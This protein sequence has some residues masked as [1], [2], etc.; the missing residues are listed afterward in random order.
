VTHIVN[1]QIN[2][3]LKVM[4]FNLFQEQ[5]IHMIQI[6]VITQFSGSMITPCRQSTSD[7]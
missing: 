3:L 4:E 5:I 6:S 2:K 7:Y 1:K